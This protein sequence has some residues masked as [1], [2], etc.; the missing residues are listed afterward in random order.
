MEQFR[1]VAK[2]VGLIRN[3][4][5]GLCASQNLDDL[6]NG[7]YDQEQNSS[8]NYIYIRYGVTTKCSTSMNETRKLQP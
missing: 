7:C 8:G 5:I 3:S 2:Q 4:S 1:D 6:D